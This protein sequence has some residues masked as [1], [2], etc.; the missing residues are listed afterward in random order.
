MTQMTLEEKQNFLADLHVGVIGINNPGQGPLTV[1]I[2][3]DYTPGGDLWVIT[4]A[5]SRKGR[6]LEVGSR[7]SLAA[8]T[9]TAPYV[10][11]SVEGA[12]SRVEPTAE[13]TLV[14]MATRY[15][16]EEM[17][18]AYAADSTLEGQVTVY[19]TP[20]RWLAVDYNKR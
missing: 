17:G 1:P 3:Y 4:G 9:E 14:N 13:E 6:L 5:D 19:M 8:Q 18:K 2:W 20:E 11:V 12:V 16:G 7:L 10:Y 15:L